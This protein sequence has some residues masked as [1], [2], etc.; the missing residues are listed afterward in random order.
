MSE[1]DIHFERAASEGTPSIHEGID[2]G[3]RDA[4]L[5]E[6]EEDVGEVV[7]AGGVG[8]GYGNS[9]STRLVGG[10]PPRA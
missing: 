9:G 1:E 8:G 4:S 7:W 6:E 5:E 10:A 3:L 2:E